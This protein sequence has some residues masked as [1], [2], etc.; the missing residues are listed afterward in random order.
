MIRFRDEHPHTF[1][2]ILCITNN[3]ESV[4]VSIK[5]R[6]GGIVRAPSPHTWAVELLSVHIC[7]NMTFE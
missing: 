4:F 7:Y 2:N 1:Y 3:V 6:F 5:D